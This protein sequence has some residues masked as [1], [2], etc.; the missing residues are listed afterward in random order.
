[1]QSRARLVPLA[2]A[3]LLLAG[4]SSPSPSPPGTLALGETSRVD[5]YSLEVGGQ[6]AFGLVGLPTQEPTTL[7]VLAHPW[8][9]HVEGYRGDLQALAEQGVL[10]VAMDFRGDTGAYKVQAGV[11][12]TVAATLAL[13]REFPSVDRTLLYGWSM[14]GEIALLA[15]ATAPPGTYDYVF[16]GAGVADLEAVWTS[17][18]YVRPFIEAETG[19][20]PDQVPHEYD[21]RSPITRIHDLLDKGVQRYFIVHGAADAPVPVEQVER[22]YDALVRAGLPVSY[23]VVTTNRDPWLCVPLVTVCAGSTPTGV[24]NHEAGGLRLMMP[25]MENRI[26]RLPDPK[27]R[28]VRGTYDGDAGTYEP[29]DVGS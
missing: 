6:E 28:A 5:S 2:L 20:P 26:D 24:A 1:M 4:C 3:A 10:G 22:F 21:I 25:L 7:V 8:G 15:V 23:Y 16:D 13:Q 12:D 14:G 17:F 9:G 11:E 19:G 27:E 29:S 18:L